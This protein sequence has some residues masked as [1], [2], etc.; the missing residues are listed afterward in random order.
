MLLIDDNDL[1]SI[2]RDI[3]RLDLFLERLGFRRSLTQQFT[4]TDGNCLFHGAH[5]QVINIFCMAQCCLTSTR[6]LWLVFQHDMAV[7]ISVKTFFL[8][9]IILL[10]QYR[11]IH[12]ED[13]MFDDD[14]FL[15][16]YSCAY[17]N[18]GINKGEVDPSALEPDPRTY[19][20]NMRRS[21]T[22]ADHPII[23]AM[24]SAIGKIFFGKTIS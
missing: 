6:H 15:R 21:G 14:D 23:S 16:K 10:L 18:K 2:A 24:A 5:D 11:N 12:T 19:L 17:L 4:P 8:L 3:P 20:D 22:H 13:C 1:P 7:E 9:N